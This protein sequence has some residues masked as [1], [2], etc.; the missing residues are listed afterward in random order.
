MDKNNG[1]YAIPGNSI[2]VTKRKLQKHKINPESQVREEFIKKHNLVFTG[3]ESHG[4][5]KYQIIEKATGKIVE[6]GFTSGQ[7]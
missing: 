3:E 2:F 6:E 5:M 4:H 1:G 7:E